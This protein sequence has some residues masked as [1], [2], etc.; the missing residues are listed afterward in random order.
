M[1]HLQIVVAASFWVAI[2]LL[3]FTAVA[4]A[5][6]PGSGTE[7]PGEG[8]SPWSAPQ[9][10]RPDS[11]RP[12]G[13]FSFKVKRSRSIRCEIHQVEAL[14]RIYVA[15]PGGA[16]YWIQLPAS[17]KISA[18]DPTSFAGRKKLEIEDL[19][20]GHRLQVTVRG[21]DDIRKVRVLRSRPAPS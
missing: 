16:Q 11:E 9:W 13:G 8:G 6:L 20:V 12:E 3:A 21:E 17:V 18:Q 7:P 2:A 10:K 1:R 4:E 19:Q 14:G 5:Q 15:E